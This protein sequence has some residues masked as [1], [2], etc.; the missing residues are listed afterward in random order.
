[1][2]ERGMAMVPTLQLFSVN[3]E[4]KLDAIL[5]EVG[6]YQR[7]GGEIWFGT[8]VGYIDDYDPAL[9]FALLRRA[10]LTFDE[11]LAALTTGPASRLPGGEARCRVE[12]GMIADLVVLGGDPAR[13]PEAGTQVRYVFRDGRRVFEA[14]T[15][16]ARRAPR[17]SRQ[18][19]PTPERGQGCTR[20]APAGRSRL[21]ASPRAFPPQR[22]GPA[23][24]GR[25]RTT[26]GGVGEMGGSTVRT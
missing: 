11:I 2:R 13:D 4:P 22:A 16:Q 15:S 19:R 24:A 12:S 18:G 10:G 26:E 20:A 3:P 8:D 9:E 14:A 21:R 7:L 17:L 6:D 5:R 25:R 1:M 23:A